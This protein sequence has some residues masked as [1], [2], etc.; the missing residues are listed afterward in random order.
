MLTTCV[1]TGCWFTSDEVRLLVNFV[2][3]WLIIFTMLVMY[4]RLYFV[5]WK[6][7]KRF[8]LFGQ[9]SSDHAAS[10]STSAPGA[11]NSGGQSGSQAKSQGAG[12]EPA[13][14]QV[15]KSSKRMRKACNPLRLSSVRHWLT[16]R[17]VG[18][19]HAYVPY[20]IHACLDPSDR[21]PN[22]PGDEGCPC[23]LCTPDYR[24]GMWIPC[25]RKG[26]Y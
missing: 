5:L 6:A 23:P 1:T 18:S 25:S 7:G 14:R 24:Q 16:S 22:L 9:S 19:A 13:Q 8:A 26:E 21:N 17:A 2:P 10:S 12:N 4:A 3:R 11:L 20:S 15:Q